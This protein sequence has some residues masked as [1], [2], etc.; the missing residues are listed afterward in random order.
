[1]KVEAEL[2]LK[3]TQFAL[4]RAAIKSIILTKVA[5]GAKFTVILTQFVPQLDALNMNIL[6]ETCLT[7]TTEDLPRMIHI[8]LHQI[9]VE[10]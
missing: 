5:V 6:M 1:M 8:A 2:K 7:T 3:V 10:T 4:L 9:G